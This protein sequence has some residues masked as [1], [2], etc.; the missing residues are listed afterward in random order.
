MATDIAC[1]KA[2][3]MHAGLVN[4][5]GIFAACGAEYVFA[6]PKE[7]LVLCE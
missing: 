6:K 3:G 2:A 5:K 4:W 7:I 1:A